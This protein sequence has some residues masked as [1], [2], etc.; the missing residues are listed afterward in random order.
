MKDA[1]NPDTLEHIS[2]DTPADWM[3][4]AGVSAP[5]Y[6]PN[7]ESCFFR[8]GAW[9]IVASTAIADAQ[10][11]EKAAVLNQVRALR[12]IALNRLTGLQLNTNVAATIS[13]L[14]A[15]RA[16]LL[17]ITTDAGVVAAADGVAT[18]TAVSAAWKIIVA[19]LTKAAPTAAS[20]FSGL[21]M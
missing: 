13:A 18:R 17:N 1:Y 2:T 7:A 12:E 15:A 5:A 11:L 8:N 21:V 9:A 16:S 3:L 20:A 6:N 19:N 4:R 10:A 14:Q